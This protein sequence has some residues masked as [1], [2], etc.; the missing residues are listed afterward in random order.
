MIAVRAAERWVALW[1]EREPPTCLAL[2][3]I[4]L[5]A[6]VLVDLVTLAAHGAAAWL[7][8]P[9]EGGGVAGWDPADPPLFYRIFPQSA[10][11]AQL[12]WLGLALSA[13][14]VGVGCFTRLAAVAHVFFSVQ[15]A[16]INGPSD[17]AIDRLIRIVLLILV[18]SP[19]GSIWSLDAKLATGSFRGV[20]KPMPAWPRYLI[21]AQLVI[22]YFGAGL[23]KG[24]TH[25][26]P[27]GGYDALYLTLQDPILSAVAGERWLQHPLGYFATRVATAVTHL[28]ELAA[29]LVLIAAY[30]RRTEGRP[31]RLRRAFNRVPVRG[32]YVLVGIVFHLSLAVVLRLGIFPFAMLACF[33]AFF[34][35]RELEAGL[36]WLGIGRRVAFS[37]SSAES[38]ATPSSSR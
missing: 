16:L 29:P 19:A 1:G 9:L 22:T 30:Y 35:P 38:A 27:W 28:W 20:S 7:W 14:G 2:I 37:S 18:L 6:V 15:A 21:L 10:G 17:R 25:W 11:S 33:P 34:H 32:A 3:R 31:G 26:Y 24:G 5:A 4:V 23:A 12:L 36:A 8:A 13:L